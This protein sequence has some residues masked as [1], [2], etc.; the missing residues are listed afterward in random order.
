MIYLTKLSDNLEKSFPS[1]IKL[2]RNFY[3]K[4]IGGLK[5]SETC[6]E[7]FCKI[8]KKKEEKIDDLNSQE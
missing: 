2:I 7:G 6:K 4:N 3:F 1:E 8:E 5:M